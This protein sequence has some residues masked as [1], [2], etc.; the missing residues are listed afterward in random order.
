MCVNFFGIFLL[1]T[2]AIVLIIAGLTM[3]VF[4]LINKKKNITVTG[5]I[6]TIIAIMMIVFGV[7][8]SIRKVVRFTID[9][10]QK[11]YNKM[12]NERKPFCHPMK[13]FMMNDEDDSL[14][15]AQMGDSGRVCIKKIICDKEMMKGCKPSNCNPSKCKSKCPSQK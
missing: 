14:M 3:L 12:L 15:N 2:L 4:G 9:G 1:A 10:K 5:S 7:I 8:F 11:M 6:L 13:D